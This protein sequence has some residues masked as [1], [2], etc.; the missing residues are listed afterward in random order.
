MESVHP[1]LSAYACAC[2]D[3]ATRTIE[4]SGQDCDDPDGAVR[5]VRRGCHLHPADC[6]LYSR[7]PGLGRISGARACAMLSLYVLGF[8]VAI[9]TAK[10]LKSSVRS[11]GVSLRIGASGDRNPTWHSMGFGCWIAARSCAQAARSFWRFLFWFGFDEPAIAQRPRF[12]FGAQRVAYLG[13]GIEP[14]IRRWASI[15]NRG[16][17]ADLG[18]RA[19]G[20][21]GT[22]G[23]IYGV[24]RR[25]T[26]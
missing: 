11:R 14:V 26:R 4:T 9:V 23:T 22:L 7:S 8:L 19:R 12:A 20:D 15:G 1:L 24:D 6:G 13:H 18:H 25:R 3:H 21:V 5:P 2:R 16:R 17:P 10:L